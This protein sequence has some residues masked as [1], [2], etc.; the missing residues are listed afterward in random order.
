M[1]FARRPV[2]M[3]FVFSWVLLVCLAAHTA[4]ACSP[5]AITRKQLMKSDVIAIGTIHIVEQ[6]EQQNGSETVIEGIAQ[7]RVRRVLKNRTALV[8]RFTFRFKQ[9]KFDGCIFGEQPLDGS[10]VKVYLSRLSPGADD[11]ELFHIE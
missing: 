6:R 2:C 10:T 4:F 5:G 9:T 1:S 3:R 8:G 11:L 7:L